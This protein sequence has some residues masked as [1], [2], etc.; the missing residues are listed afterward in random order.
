MCSVLTKQ[1]LIHMI[2]RKLR[3]TDR[4][5][6]PKIFN[7]LWPNIRIDLVSFEKETYLVDDT[8][9]VN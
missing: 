3:D 4:I 1:Q 7:I 2:L 5:T 9:R 8:K 6:L